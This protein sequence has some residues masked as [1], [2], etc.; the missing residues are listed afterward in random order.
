MTP[1]QNVRNGRNHQHMIRGALMAC[2]V[3]VRT[4]LCTHLIERLQRESDE[5]VST[6]NLKY[7]RSYTITS[8]AC[9]RRVDWDLVC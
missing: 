8:G 5:R 3:A 1:A 7:L 9:G 6:H 4:C 2:T